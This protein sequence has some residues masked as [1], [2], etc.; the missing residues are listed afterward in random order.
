VFR[1]FQELLTNVARH[2]QA[3]RVD[4]R[5]GVEGDMMWL[6]VQDNGRG[7]TEARINS[8]KSL[9]FLGMRERALPFDGK[10]EIEGQRGKGTT[11]TIRI[12]LRTPPRHVHAERAAD[13]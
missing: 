9:G 6:K 13:V 5:M 10:I 1:I 7:I 3:P 12:P 4:V 8:P 11:V 2:A